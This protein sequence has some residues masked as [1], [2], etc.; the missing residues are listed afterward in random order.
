MKATGIVR[1][2]DDL[3]RVVIPKEIRRSLRIREGAPLE[4]YVDADGGLI[5]KKYSPLKEM[6]DIARDFVE[7]LSEKLKKPAFIVDH[8]GVVA[9]AGTSSEDWR[10]L[11]T[12]ETVVRIMDE[13]RAVFLSGEGSVWSFTHC[14]V[15]PVIAEGDALGAVILAVDAPDDEP[16]AL[17]LAETAAGF[18]A[19]QMI[20]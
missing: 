8:D 19:R 15:A 3:G 12:P 17:K 11:E 9:A 2:I 1:R 16:V 4:I 5:L 6:A 18:L 13:R 10:R 20:T 14:A 7:S